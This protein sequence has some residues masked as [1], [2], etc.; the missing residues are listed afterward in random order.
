[1]T[2][3]ALDGGRVIDPGRGIDGRL[4]VAVNRGRV[5]ALG[6]VGGV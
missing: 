1:M 5:T 4:G 6:E 3:L 2:D